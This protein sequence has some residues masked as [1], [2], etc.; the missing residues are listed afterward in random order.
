MY[1]I[2]VLIIFCAIFIIHFIDDDMLFKSC[3]HAQG[4]ERPQGSPPHPTFC[5]PSQHGS[6]LADMV[7]REER[8]NRPLKN[9][10]LP[11]QRKNPDR[12]CMRNT[13]RALDFFASLHLTIFERPAN[14]EFFNS[15]IRPLLKCA[16][17]SATPS[18]KC[19]PRP[20]FI[21]RP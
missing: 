3:S 11:R 10:D 12:L 20:V 5:R 17:S 18:P 4:E 21:I 14:F 13:P 1:Y 15:Q 7:G 6:I 19:P 9:G 16:L 2:Y 8:D